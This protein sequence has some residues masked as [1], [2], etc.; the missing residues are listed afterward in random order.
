[1]LAQYTAQAQESLTIESCIF[2]AMRV[3]RSPQPL[4]GVLTINE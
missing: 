3:Y 1:M 4:H 2:A